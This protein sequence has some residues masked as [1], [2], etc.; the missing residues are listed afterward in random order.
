LALTWNGGRKSA[1]LYVNGR[2]IT[3]GEILDGPTQ[4][5]I[6]PIRIGGFATRPDGDPTETQFHGMLSDLR[7]Y[8]GELSE[9]EITKLASP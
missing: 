5:E 7:I 3:E 4:S 9:E 2:K 6:H 1:V 8:E